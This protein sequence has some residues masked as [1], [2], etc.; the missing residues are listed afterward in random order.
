MLVKTQWMCILCPM[1][2][3]GQPPSVEILG[4]PV[5]P[6]PA[7]PVPT[8]PIHNVTFHVIT[9]ITKAH[10]GG[11]TVA[12]TMINSTCR[13]VEWFELPFTGARFELSFGTGFC[14]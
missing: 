14:Y 10:T 9:A 3:E 1:F 4:G 13:H 6:P 5:A 8:P 2:W 7:P 11:I 12:I